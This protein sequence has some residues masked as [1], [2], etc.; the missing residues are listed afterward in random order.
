MG[1]ERGGELGENERERLDSYFIS[2]HGFND[3]V[4]ALKAERIVSCIKDDNLKSKVGKKKR[5]LAWR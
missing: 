2:P 4:G 5:P 3:F 1:G